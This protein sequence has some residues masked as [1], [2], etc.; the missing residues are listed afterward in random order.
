M[1]GNK[2]VLPDGTPCKCRL[3][4]D[5]IFSQVR[6]VDVPEQYVG[7]LF[8]SALV[9][10]DVGPSYAPVLDGLHREITTLQLHNHNI[11]ICSPPNHSKT[12]WAYSCI[13]HLFRQRVPVCPILDML[14]I[15]RMFN[16]C[17][18]TS[19]WYEVPYLFAKIPTEVNQTIRSAILTLV[20][21]RVRRGNSTFFLYEGSWGM[22]TYDDRF[23]TLKSMQGDGSF[24]TLD[25]KSYRNKEVRDDTV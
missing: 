22:L 6:G 7:I 23:G 14:E 1:C 25:V 24:H 17:S 2:G 13:Q 19:D 5:A 15:A 12:V 21:R 8:N 11:V 16:E 3:E 18:D 20:D 4:T 9:P 10:S